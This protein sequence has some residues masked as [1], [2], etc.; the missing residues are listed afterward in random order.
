MSAFGGKADIA[1]ARW[2]VGSS[3]APCSSFPSISTFERNPSETPGY[4]LKSQYVQ[5]IAVHAGYAVRSNGHTVVVI[6]RRKSG[7][8]YARIGVDSHQDHVLDA[9]N[10]EQGL[11]SVPWKQSSLFLLSMT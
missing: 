7:V 9:E 10:F 11:Q 8:Q 6:E 4:V 5:V 1:Q 3:T 2:G